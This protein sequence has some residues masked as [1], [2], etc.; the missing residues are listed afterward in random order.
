MGAS[1]AVIGAG[2]GGLTTA[3]F[4]KKNGLNVTVYESAEEIKP[5][6]AGIVMAGNAMQIFRELGLQEKVEQSGNKVS[7]MKITDEQYRLLSEMD[8][9]LFEQKYNVH[10][11]AVYRA[12][13]QR[14]L[15][16]T[17]GY[18][19]LCLGKRL[20]KIERK[21]NVFRLMFKDGSEAEHDCLIGADGIRSVVREQL[22][23]T[24]EIRNT[25][26]VCWRGL[27]EKDFSEKYRNEAYELWGRG[28]RFG[29]VQINSRQVYWYAVVNAH[30]VTDELSLPDLFSDFH[31]EIREL[32]KITSADTIIK[33]EIIDLKPMQKWFTK[34]VCLIG[35][36]A[37]ATTPNMG[38]G[39]CQAIEDAYAIGQLLQKGKS[40]NETFKLY[41]QLRKSK[42]H[43]IVNNS[44]KLG[45]IAHF[46]S[47]I[48]VKFRNF[49][50]KIV[51]AA[52]NRKQLEKVLDISYLK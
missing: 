49:L 9:S 26:Q 10:N 32:I 41:E 5:V 22:F 37:H 3:L 17:L 51:P 1:V 38:Q 16:E 2:P 15:A 44:W 6:G 29:F 21:E 42:A 14:I 25:G 50:F 8:L 28:K 47:W 46:E 20:S 12:D 24:H 35:D 31:P 45:K 27:C 4:F 33:N 39:A 23:G 52:A 43:G 11:V 18:E 36:A 48:A 19:H 13:L 34:N 30:L 40:L 7:K